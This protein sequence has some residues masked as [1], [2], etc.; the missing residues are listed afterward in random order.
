MQKITQKA[1][2]SNSVKFEL[3]KHMNHSILSSKEFI[4]WSRKQHSSESKFNN[5]SGNIAK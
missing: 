1:I 4:S 3:K 2:R 5:N